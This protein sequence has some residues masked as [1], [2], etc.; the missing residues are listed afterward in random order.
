MTNRDSRRRLAGARPAGS[1]H[2]APT[3]ALM[4]LLILLLALGAP[5]GAGAQMLATPVLQN[6]FTNP[7]VTAAANF[8]STTG[9]RAYGLAAAWAPGR[10]RFALSGG[11]GWL[12]P[13]AVDASARTTYGAR[14][15]LGVRQ[16]MSGALG[17]AGFVGVGGAAKKG[18]TP[19]VTTLPVGVSVGWRH[20]VG[21]TRGVSVYAAPFY[22]LARSSVGGSTVNSGVFRV[23]G[24]VDFSLTPR[25]GVTIGAETGAEAKAGKPGPRSSVFGAGLS[26]AFK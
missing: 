16:F 2:P 4:P 18:D 19:A 8:G 15:A 9:A 6:A 12:D 14:L 13:A 5:R 3:L 7:G 1:L 10:G 20:A 25:I 23:S 17:V 24:G 22:S 21:A 26:Y 11:V